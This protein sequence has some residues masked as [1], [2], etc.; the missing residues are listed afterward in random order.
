M[1]CEQ[2]HKPIGTGPYYAERLESHHWTLKRNPRY[3]GIGGLIDIDRCTARTS[4]HRNDWRVTIGH[5]KEILG[6]LALEG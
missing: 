3:F 1:D 5:S 6:I 4:E 2:P